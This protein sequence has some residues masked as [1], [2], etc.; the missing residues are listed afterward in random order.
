[1]AWDDPSPR[2]RPGS[3]S[4]A[5]PGAQPGYGEA[6]ISFGRWVFRVLLAGTAG[7]LVAVGMKAGLADWRGHAGHASGL[8]VVLGVAAGLVV[9]ALAWKHVMN[10]PPRHGLS[11]RVRDGG[12][13]SR[14][15]GVLDTFVAADVVADLVEVAID[16]AVDL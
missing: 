1:M 12:W 3:A 6:P 2:A 4:A 10:R 8:D 14:P 7:V 16:I 15:D 13:G 11:A 9:A 5:A